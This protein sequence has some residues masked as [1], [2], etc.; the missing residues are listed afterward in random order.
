MEISSNWIWNAN[1]SENIENAHTQM[2]QRHHKMHFYSN[3]L[4]QF[5]NM[6]NLFSVNYLCGKENPYEKLPFQSRNHN[7]IRTLTLF[8]SF[9]RGLIYRCLCLANGKRKR[10]VAD[11]SSRWW[12]YWSC[13]KHLEMRLPSQKRYIN[14]GDMIFNRW[15]AKTFGLE[16]NATS[17][18]NCAHQRFA[19]HYALRCFS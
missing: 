18:N 12:S 7:N 5:F 6:V 1:V 9:S 11:R 17:T 19:I 4:T 14:V 8:L 16:T 3:K 10:S 15:D 2:H 13:C